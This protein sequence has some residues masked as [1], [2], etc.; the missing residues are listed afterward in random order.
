MSFN[1]RTEVQLDR[2]NLENGY[3]QPSA[4]QS[5]SQRVY[6]GQA[7]GFVEDPPAS[8]H[9][10]LSVKPYLPISESNGILAFGNVTVGNRDPAVNNAPQ[11]FTVSVVN[12]IDSQNIKA[13]FTVGDIITFFN[14]RFPTTIAHNNSSWITVAPS[15]MFDALIYPKIVGGFATGFQFLGGYFDPTIPI[16]PFTVIPSLT[17]DVQVITTTAPEPTKICKIMPKWNPVTNTFQY[18]CMSPG[19]S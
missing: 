11:V 3:I 16:I 2:Y 8:N 19:A 12:C 10:A 1:P 18:Y 13:L 14:S 15:E 17:G 4:S 6:E 7:I 5:F 9:W